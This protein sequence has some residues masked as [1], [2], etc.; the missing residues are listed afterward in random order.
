MTKQ[1]RLPIATAFQVSYVFNS[2]RV[3]ST[4]P[5]YERPRV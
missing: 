5:D 1:S 3:P 2:V 4:K